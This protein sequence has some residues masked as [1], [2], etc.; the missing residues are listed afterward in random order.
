M[1]I[2]EAIARINGWVTDFVVRISK[3][4]TKDLVVNHEIPGVTPEMIDT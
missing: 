3:S 2:R 1:F 4:E